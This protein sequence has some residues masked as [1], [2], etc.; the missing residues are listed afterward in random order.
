MANEIE[1][2]ELGKVMKYK[3]REGYITKMKEELMEKV[4]TAQAIILMGRTPKTEIRKRLMNPKNPKGANNPEFSYLEHAYVEE[5][6]NLAFNFNWDAVVEET[7]WN[8]D[9][10][11]LRGYIEVRFPKGGM[12]VRKTGFGGARYIAN[13]PNMSRGDAAKSAYSDMIKNAATKL[14]IG[15]DLYRHEE[16]EQEKVQKVVAA[17]PA[18]PANDVLNKPATETQISTIRNMGG[19]LPDD[20]DELKKMTFGQAATMIRELSTKKKAAP[21]KDEQ[22]TIQ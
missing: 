16:K 2:K 7:T 3:E 18:Q 8:G 19:V 1:V 12:T 14:G 5:L 11:M 13:N 20:P 4:G 15:L 21:K 6:L 10:V 9:D 22:T 17:A